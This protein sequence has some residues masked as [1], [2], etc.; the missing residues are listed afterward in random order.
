MLPPSGVHL[1]L[2]LTSLAPAIAIAIAAASGEDN[3]DRQ[4]DHLAALRAVDQV[5]LGSPSCYG[6]FLYTS[7]TPFSW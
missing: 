2:Q 5:C 1:G 6:S 3:A 4:E 7:I